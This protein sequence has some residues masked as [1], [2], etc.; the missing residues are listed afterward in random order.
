MTD[1]DVPLTTRGV[2]RTRFDPLRDSNPLTDVPDEPF[3]PNLPSREDIG[4]VDLVKTVRQRIVDLAMLDTAE[5]A[6]AVTLAEKAMGAEGS[7]A[8]ACL[9]ELRMLMDSIRASRP[10]GEVKNPTEDVL[11]RRR[12]R[13]TGA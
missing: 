2:P 5:G 8:A 10:A 13:R 9:H 7:A 11:G 6:M 4:P 1:P 12:E 3:G